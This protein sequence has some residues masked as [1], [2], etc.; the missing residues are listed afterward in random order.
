MIQYF[1]IQ[2]LFGLLSQHLFGQLLYSQIIV[3]AV[4]KEYFRPFYVYIKI[5]HIYH[6]YSKN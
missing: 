1:G 5:T 4:P 3:Q 2:L 6:H